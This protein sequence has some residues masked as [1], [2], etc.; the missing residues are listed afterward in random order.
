MSLCGFKK[1]FI[2]LLAYYSIISYFTK[3]I[4]NYSVKNLLQ[5]LFT[6]FVIKIYFRKLSIILVVGRSVIKTLYKSIL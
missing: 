5:E 3:L 4:V 2:M 6:E 1:L